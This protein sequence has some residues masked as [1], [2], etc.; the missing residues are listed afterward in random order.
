VIVCPL[1]IVGLVI[2]IVGIGLTTREIVFVLTQA[3]LNPE[4]LYV[5]VIV[6]LTLIVLVVAVVFQE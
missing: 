4:T 6:G 2:A 3:P 1:H 5:V